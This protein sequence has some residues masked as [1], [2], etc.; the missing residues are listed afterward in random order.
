M[1]PQRPDSVAPSLPGA[2]KCFIQIVSST[3]CILHNIYE[4]SHAQRPL[5]SLVSK[6]LRAPYL[7]H[8]FHQKKVLTV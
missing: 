1:K 4:D 2:N 5:P 7:I 3:I 8:Q 6:N